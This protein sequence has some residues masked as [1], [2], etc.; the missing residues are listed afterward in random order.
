MTDTF[1]VLPFTHLSTR[2]N[3]DITPCCRSRDTLG[4]IRDITFE[5]AWNSERQQ[6]LRKDLLSGIRNKYCFQCW[7]MEDQGSVS[8]RQSLNTP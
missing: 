2:P 7:D 3:G 8:M 4:N 5:Q 1:C 6:L